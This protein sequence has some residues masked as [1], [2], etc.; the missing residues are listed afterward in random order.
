[1]FLGEGVS[2]SLSLLIRKRHKMWQPFVCSQ[3]RQLWDVTAGAATA[4]LALGWRGDHCGREQSENC[5]RDTGSSSTH[6]FLEMPKLNGL[7]IWTGAVYG[8]QEE[9]SQPTP[10]PSECVNRETGDADITDAMFSESTV[11]IE[12]LKIFLTVSGATIKTKASG[13]WGYVRL[14]VSLMATYTVCKSERVYFTI[15]V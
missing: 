2:E 13:T 5:G 10:R 14:S 4:T 15:C 9:A 1:M 8:L 3:N 7:A 6:E 12:L 11:H